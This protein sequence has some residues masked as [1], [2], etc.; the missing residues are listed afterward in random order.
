M[1]FM[2]ARLAIGA[3]LMLAC[4][5]MAVA[6]EPFQAFV[7]GLR[8]RQLYDMA[9]AYLE[10]SKTNPLV[11][12]ADKTRIPFEEGRVLLDEAGN[13]RDSAARSRKLDEAQQRLDAFIAARGDD[14]FASEARLQLGNVYI[15]R[16]RSEIAAASRPSQA[17]KRAESMKRAGDWL[18]KAQR[19]LA[20]AEGKFGAEFNKF[21]KA[22]DP[23]DR[24]QI[25]ARDRA[26]V[27]LI[28]AQMFAATVLAEQAK[29]QD[30]K[31][32][33]GRKLLE[34]AALKYGEIHKKFNQYLVALY[35]RLYQGQA[36]LELGKQTEA[37]ACLEEVL[38]QAAASPELRPLADKTLPIALA[39]WLG[40]KDHQFDKAID[41]SQKWLQ[42]ASRAEQHTSDGLTVA[43]YAAEA[44]R[45]RAAAQ[46]KNKDDA[47]ASDNDLKEAARLAAEVARYPGE[48][49]DAARQLLA[50]LRK[51]AAPELPTTFADAL[52][53]GRSALD[54]AG[55][56]EQQIHEAQSGEADAT[57]LTELRR[58]FSSAVQRAE[59]NLRRALEL[60]DADTQADSMAEAQYLLAYT[61]FLAERYYDA[62][63]AAEFVA[64]H[65]TD[66]SLARS[67][68]KIALASY[69][70]AYNAQPA[71]QREAEL[72]CMTAITEHIAATWPQEPEAAEAWMILSEVALRAGNVEIANT[73]LARIPADSPGRAEA[74]L[75]QGQA[76]WGR[77]LELAGKNDSRPASAA[78]MGKLL[79]DAQA[80][81]EKAVTQARA[82]EGAPSYS[83]LAAELTLAQIFNVQGKYD[84]ALAIL[85]RKETGPLSLV[86]AKDPLIGR[87]PYVGEALKTALRAYVG[88]EQIEQAE[89]IMSQ[90]DEQYA[91]KPDAEQSLTAIYVSLG[92]ELEQQVKSLEA[93]GDSVQLAKVL[94]AFQL[95]ID[96]VVKQETKSLATLN[97]IGETGNR[98]G[99]ALAQNPKKGD[100]AKKYYERGATAYAKL[101]ERATQDEKLASNVPAIRLR[102]SRCLRGA[103][104]WEGAITQL[105]EILKSNPSVLDVQF[106]AARVFQAWGAFDGKRY[107]QAI[108]GDKSPN[109]PEIWGFNGIASRLRRRPAQKEAY[110]EARY[111][112]AECSYRLALSR[113]GAEQ[114]DGLLAVERL[115]HSN[116][117]LDAELGGPNWRPKYDQ[118]LRDVQRAAGRTPSGLPSLP[119]DSTARSL[120]QSAE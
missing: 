48:H 33:A 44:H 2:L 82:R 87:G 22:I 77:Y 79:A 96:R 53:E 80:L 51:V 19:V 94:S 63:V 99:D 42:Q 105:R 47:R 112:V 60:R 11:S 71:D 101:L 93:T 58:S 74:D 86:A 97:W 68:A 89:K 23:A 90:L 17:A 28:Q 88:A 84:P 62:A 81:L 116:Y 20:E 85:E 5:R 109:V 61:L 107:Q 25:D 118:L 56:L 18:I 113:T 65:R 4:C 37:L 103:H 55:S 78:E 64:R 40:D 6:G 50:Q 57:K 110:E 66:S 39:A 16:S 15:E 9:M 41:A 104:D 54:E 73:Y 30:L 92:R 34:Q 29:T 111:L 46:K 119:P 52:N 43:W 115:I 106:E 100:E 45:R 102:L 67:A 91:G 32:E 108:R 49:Q 98:L 70:E 24:P 38:Q 35:A 7:D 31:S 13:L 95:F 72:R 12:E 69:L 120:P 10:Q 8:R 27:N 1:G 75:K 83:L 14:P 26:R 21:P 59:N 114:A 3:G 36:L 117:S 76:L